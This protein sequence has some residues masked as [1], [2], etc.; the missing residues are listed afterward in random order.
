[1]SHRVVAAALSFVALSLL[2]AVAQARDGRTVLIQDRCDPASFNAAL[3]AEVCTR[4]GGVTFGEFLR[5]LNPHDGGHGAWRFSRDDAD[6]KPGEP[7]TVR[8]AGGETHSF[9]EVKAFGATPIPP[10]ADLLNAALPPGTPFAEPVDNNNLR[11]TAVGA[12]FD[13]TGLTPGT[14]RF[15]C[16][17]HPWMR[18]TVTQRR[19]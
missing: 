5:R 17:I 14:H 19:S 3:N 15:Q 7:L 8:N 11:F 4:D 6:L 2:P 16:L 18:T 9:S 12:S 1:M 13:I 10:F